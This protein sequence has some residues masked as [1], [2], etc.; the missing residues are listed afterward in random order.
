M[1]EQAANGDLA[2]VSQTQLSRR[3]AGAKMDSPRK[4]V[5]FAKSPSTALT[6]RSQAS[7]SFRG[8][9]G[10]ET[11]P[12]PEGELIIS[13]ECLVGAVP[14]SDSCVLSEN[15]ERMGHDHVWRKRVLLLT[16]SGLHLLS[17]P[18]PLST[19][20]VKEFHD[21]ANVL[22]VKHIDLVQY[23]QGVLPKGRNSSEGT[24]DVVFGGSDVLCKSSSGAWLQVH[25][26]A[27]GE[28]GVEFCIACDADEASVKTLIIKMP[29]KACLEWE[30]KTAQLAAA[31]RLQRTKESL[32]RWQ[33]LQARASSMYQA[34]T[35]QLLTAGAIAVNFIVN[36]ME[37]EWEPVEGSTTEL[38]F[39]SCD[40]GFAGFFVLDLLL[41]MV[42][43]SQAYI[44]DFQSDHIQSDH[45][46]KIL[47]LIA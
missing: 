36:V 25:G 29:H 42:A 31:K 11:D 38:I 10:R 5:T 35:V 24:D 43:L 26:P 28:H 18:T 12:V 46:I 6:P 40:V 3:G 34:R 32:S 16:D 4:S 15:V 2:K 44:T 23:T 22:T 27:D 33:L 17:E 30:T 9:Q 8:S 13:E 37:A 39:W 14:A 41:H 47:D 19:P 21:L 7:A 1:A 45:V 20:V